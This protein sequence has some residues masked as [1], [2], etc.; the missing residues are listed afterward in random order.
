MSDIHFVDT[1]LRDGPQSLWAGRMSTDAMLPALADIDAAG[2]QGI[3]FFLP[4]TQFVRHA[5][6]MQENPW[7]WLNLGVPLAPN[8]PLRLHGGIEFFGRAIPMAVYGLLLDRLVELGITTTRFSDPWNDAQGLLA[9]QSRV[10]SGHGFKSVLNI[11]YTESPRHTLDYYRRR[12]REIAAL[13]PYRICFKDVGGLLTPDKTRELVPVMLEAAGDIPVEFHAHSNNGLASL[14]YVIA[15][16]LG[17]TIFHTAIPPLSSGTSQPSV[18]GTVKNLEALG[19]TPAIDLAPLERVRDHLMTVASASGLPQG[20]ARDF[21]QTLYAHQVPGGM[22]SHLTL[23]LEQLGF[24]DRL[25]EVLEEAARVRAEFGYPIMVTPLSQFVG[26]QAALN[27]LGAARYATV[28]DEVIRYALGEFGKEAP[29][30]M[31]QE[32][33]HR[34]LD[35]PRAREIAAVS[36]PEP[37][38]EEIR[39]RYGRI[40]DEELVTRFYVGDDAAA[41]FHAPPVR[42]PTTYEE[43]AAA[44]RPLAALL[45]RVA[46]DPAWR[47]LDLHDGRTT[48]TLERR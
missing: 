46:A 12:A 45:G 28:T 30:V 15:A 5:K 41:V 22:I 17:I 7:D 21:D 37:T 23:Q 19:F 1:T 16:Q 39:A 8:T 26:S 25:P 3:E 42:Y 18:F 43:Y 2:F 40:S 48:I 10:L 33:R 20:L 13:K 9:E 34:I 38:I 29:E 11:I 35:R 32:V 47:H 44:H 24:A 14:N 6:E 27:V 36:R 4:G 31:D